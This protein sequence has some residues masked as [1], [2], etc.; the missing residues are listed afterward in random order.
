MRGQRFAAIGRWM[1]IDPATA[2]L[3]LVASAL[4]KEQ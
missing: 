4:S 2:K 3:C 1:N